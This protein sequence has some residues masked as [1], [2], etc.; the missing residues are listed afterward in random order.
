MAR[1]LATRNFDGNEM[2]AGDVMVRSTADLDPRNDF[3]RFLG[4]RLELSGKEVGPAIKHR[5]QNADDR[6][7][8]K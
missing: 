5:C 1:Q 6:E 4:H 8:A 7:K 2:D 3:R